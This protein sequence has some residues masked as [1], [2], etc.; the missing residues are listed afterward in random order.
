MIVI[1]PSQ[2][3]WS[4]FEEEGISYLT[5]FSPDGKI[6]QIIWGKDRYL[7]QIFTFQYDF[8]TDSEFILFSFL[9]GI[10]KAPGIDLLT[11]N[12]LTISRLTTSLERKWDILIDFNRAIDYFLRG[13]VIKDLSVFVWHSIM[14]AYAVVYVNLTHELNLEEIRNSVIITRP[15]AEMLIYTIWDLYSGKPAL[16]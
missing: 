4:A 9:G 15:M 8:I 13:V 5:K 14:N 3:A 11:E 1:R 16:I 6:L 2:D 7:R 10:N 12:N